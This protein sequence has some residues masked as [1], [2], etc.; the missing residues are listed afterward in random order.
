MGGDAQV[1]NLKGKTPIQSPKWTL[2]GGYSH[3][4][5]LGNGTLT[6]GIQTLFKSDY[7]LSPFNFAMDKQ[8]AYSK[9]DINLTYAAK[10]GKWDVGVFAQ[11]LEDNRILTYAA[12]TGGTINLYNWIFGTPRTYGIQANVRF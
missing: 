1:V 4:F 9:T 12:F 2:V 8:G 10:T 5:S 6:A 7:Y 11:N 3:D